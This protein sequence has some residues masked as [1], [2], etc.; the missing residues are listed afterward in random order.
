MYDMPI[1][2]LKGE[3]LTRLRLRLSINDLFYLSFFFLGIRTNTTAA[4][5]AN[6][7]APVTATVGIA[8]E[9]FEST[10]LIF[11]STV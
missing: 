9:L 3:N 7:I 4:K 2:L 8:Q 5:E 11:T 1:T 6:A 10:N